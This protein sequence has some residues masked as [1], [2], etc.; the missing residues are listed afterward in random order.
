MGELPA[1]GAGWQELSKSE[2]FGLLARERVGRVA[3]VDDLGPIVLPVNFVLDRHMVVFRTDGGSKLDTAVRGGRVAFEVDGTDETAR[4][5]WSVLVRGEAVEVTD[6]A[7]LVRLR[8]LRL[9]PWAPGVKTHYVRILPAVLTGR[10]ISAPAG[11]SGCGGEPSPG[12]GP[13]HGS[14]VRRWEPR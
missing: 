11:P 9:H 14:E 6:P 13:A 1:S 7:E 8:Q 3:F 12:R 4:T 5:G 2:C 10:R